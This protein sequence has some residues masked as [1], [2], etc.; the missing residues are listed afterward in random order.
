MEISMPFV[1]P[2]DL[3]MV[4]ESLSVPTATSTDYVPV[5]ANV[6]EGTMGVIL[7]LIHI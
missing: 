3:V 5:N 7:S 1:N 6:P 2:G 4:T